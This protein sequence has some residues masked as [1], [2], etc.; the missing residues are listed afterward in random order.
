M[1]GTRPVLFLFLTPLLLAAAQP[2]DEARTEI[3]A[4]YQR[5]LEAMSRGDI[6]AARQI[7]T[8]DWIS[9][10]V[11]QKPRT[12]QELEPFVRRDIAS[13]KTPPNWSAIWKPDYERNGTTTGIQIYDIKLDGNNAIVL[14]LVGST[15][16]ETIDQKARSVW[17]GS[18]VRDTWIRTKDGWKRHMHEKLTV[19]ERM[20]DGQ[21]VKQ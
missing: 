7:D 8:P 16:T 15:H 17:T 10:V 5:S 11:G 13:V 18:H 1:T 21:P 6:D 14:C 20:I 19:N 2:A 3:V 9:I 12:W 4:A